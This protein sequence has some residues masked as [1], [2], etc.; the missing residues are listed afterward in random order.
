MFVKCGAADKFNAAG[1]KPTT[2]RIGC[3]VF[4][5]GAHLID[6]VG[7]VVAV[8]YRNRDVRP[9]HDVGFVRSYIGNSAILHAND[10]RGLLAL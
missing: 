5:C 7:Q 2:A 9:T 3:C 8:V 10:A 1:K 6:N 4:N